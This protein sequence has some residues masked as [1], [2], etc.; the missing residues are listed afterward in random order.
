MT[1]GTTAVLRSNDSVDLLYQSIELKHR[2]LRKAWE[3][4]LNP[5]QFEE[6]A[7]AFPPCDPGLIATGSQLVVQMKRPRRKIGSL[8]MADETKDNERFNEQIGVVV[9]MGPLAYR[10]RKNITE[11]W[12]EG[13]WCVV[14]DYIRIP[15]YGHE[16]WEVPLNN[17]VADLIV[18]CTIED[19]NIRGVVTCNP[20]L[21]RSY[22]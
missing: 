16:R 6:L 12:P 22:V 21:V 13:P 11:W 2:T 18:F 20:M 10:D 17:D 3:D 14:D 8:I 19:K 1:K 5:Q 7:A 9:S 4:T 15:K